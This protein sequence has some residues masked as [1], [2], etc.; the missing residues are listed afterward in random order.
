MISVILN[1]YKRPV[2]LEKQIECVLNQSIDIKPENIH[3]WY[4]AA[5]INQPDPENKNINTYR[6]NWNTKF[7]GRFMIPLLCRTEFVAI[8]DDD[9]FSPPR[10]F[11]NCVKTIDTHN[12]ILGGSGV[13]IRGIRKSYAKKV[14][15]NGRKSVDPIEVDFVGHTWFF[16]QEWAKY[17]WQENPYSWDNAEDMT[18]SYLCQ[19]HGGIKT[20]VPPH[21][22]DNLDS[23]C[24]ETLMAR[25]HGRDKNASWKKGNH[26]P[27]RLEAIKHYIDN[28][29]KTLK[30]VQ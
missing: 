24:T 4:N 8:F 13:I 27:L 7:Y 17:M 2:T 10:W 22:A 9:I 15:W 23:W 16:R 26:V 6:C 14:G 11:E 28:G 30:S 21:N 3:V 29:W 20:Y 25:H 19:K 1:V 18:F 5:G 12:G